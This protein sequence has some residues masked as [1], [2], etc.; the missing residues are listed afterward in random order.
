MPDPR[1]IDAV[2]LRHF[3][4]VQRMDIIA[5]RLEGY[6][7][8]HWTHAVQDELL[9]EIA[10]YG[11]GTVLASGVLGNPYQVPDS[12]QLELIRTQIALGGTAGSLEQLGEAETFL[13]ADRL[14]GTLITDDFDAFDFA[15]K[16]LGPNRVL[17][18]VDL[19]REAVLAG[20]LEPSEAQQVAD[21]IRNSGRY[22]R[23][24]HPPTLTAEYFDRRA[25]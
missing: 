10:D 24:G 6:P 1:L 23:A 22:L 12:A 19:L 20:E 3:G 15:E 2:T 16:N 9:R 7:L 17:D 8:P 25:P 21:A 11:C 13:A 14:N 5:T 18:T 4:T